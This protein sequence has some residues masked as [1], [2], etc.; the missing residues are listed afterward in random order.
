MT[1]SETLDFLYARLPLFSRIGDRALK[2]GL[3]NILALSEK[4]DNPHKNGKFIHVAG[5]NG[6]GSVSHMLAAI[7]QSAGYKT[8]LYTSPHLKDLRERIRIDGEMI[9]EDQVV[10]FVQ[11]IQPYIETIDPSFFEMTVAMAMD[12]FASQET[13]IAVIETG[14]GGRLDS[15]NII[16]PV[17]TIITNIG[18]DHMNLLGNSLDKIAQEKAGIIKQGIP[19]IIGETHPETADVFRQ[20]A[21]EKNAPI[22]FADLE[23][24]VTNWQYNNR[25]LIV[26]VAEKNSQ[27]HKKYHLDLTGNYQTLN[28][29]PV[30][31][32]VR[33]LNQSGFHITSEALATGLK[34][35]RQL[36]GFHGRWETI[37]R[38]PDIVLDVAHNEDGMRQLLNQIEISEFHHLHIVLGMAKEKDVK[39]VLSMLPKYASYYFT[40]AHVPRAIPGEEMRQKALMHGLKGET[41]PDVNA[42]ISAAKA[43]AHKDDL[44]IVCG[45][46]FLVGEIDEI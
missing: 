13:D 1:Y 38:K 31:T 33:E 15:T 23:Y 41:Y 40:N 39:K 42:A 46:I 2:F 32:A 12:Y 25:E 37:H 24:L 34:N 20:K 10:A 5:T 21:K 19:I 8:G 4:L 14:L 9:P 36:T 17:L 28:L 45:S 27:D 16:N 22:I 29:L 3:S 43:Q 7:L 35:T 18:Y 6:K 26:E 30:L 11:R 44:I